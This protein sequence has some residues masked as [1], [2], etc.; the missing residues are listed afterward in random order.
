M[1]SPSPELTLGIRPNARPALMFRDT[2]SP[3]PQ[4][5]MTVHFWYFELHWVFDP[6]AA[7][8]YILNA[9]QRRHLICYAS[10]DHRTGGLI[11]LHTV[12]L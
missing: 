1:S 8:G 10:R 6:V 5:R 7:H 3:D 2:G 12:G 4:V 9:R 11:L